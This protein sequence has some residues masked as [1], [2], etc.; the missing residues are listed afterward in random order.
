M[1]D[2]KK[3]SSEYISRHKYFSARRDSY[4]TA[5]GK[6]VDPY[7]VVELPTSAA[8]VAITEDGQM[9]LVK[10]Y[11]YAVDEELLEIPGGFIDPGELPMQAIERELLEET[12]YS[13]SSIHYLANTTANPGLLNNYT[14]LFLALGGKKVADQSLDHNEEIEVI[15]KPVGEV[16]IMLDQNEIKQSMHALCLFYAFR[17][18]DVKEISF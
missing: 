1:S 4:E 11:R 8:A 9:I 7:F 2:F 14:H 12:G 17:F 16:R 5:D 3:I 13:F 18:I 10:Q 6:T 15:L